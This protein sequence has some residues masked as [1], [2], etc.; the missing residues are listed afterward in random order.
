M[1]V[2][3]ILLLLWSASLLAQ[4]SPATPAPVSAPA[5]T[6]APASLQ[7]FERDTLANIIAAERGHVF[8]L[9]L[10]DLDCPYCLKSM[11]FMAARQKSDPALRVITVAT[12]SI[13]E[14]EKVQQ[15]LQE[16][17]LQGPRYAFGDET[18]EVLRY[19]IDPKWRG[20]KPRAYRYDADG[21]RQTYTGVLDANQLK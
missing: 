21:V 5:Q 4:A 6:P 20:E 12:D 9:V 1:K 17:G 13:D 16:I 18:P 14:Q 3:W 8:W 10:W 11:R 19:G 7:P 15:R 2:L